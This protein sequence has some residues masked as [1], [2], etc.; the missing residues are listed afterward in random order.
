MMRKGKEG[1]IALP[2]WVAMILCAFIVGTGIGDAQIFNRGSGS[3]PAAPTDPGFPTPVSGKVRALKGQQITFELTSETKSPASIVEYLVRDFPLAGNIDSLQTKENA[4]SKAVMKYTPKLNTAAT[5]DVFTFSVRY[6][7]GRWSAP[8][9]FEIELIDAVPIMEGPVAVDF[10]QVMIG[11]EAVKEIYIRNSGNAIYDKTLK[12]QEPWHLV[13]PK[14]GRVTVPIGGSKM[15][16]VAFRPF[17]TESTTYQF[18]VNRNPGGV[19]QLR[20]D[21]FKPFSIKNPELK[22]VANDKNGTREGSITVISHAPKTIMLKVKTS[23]RLRLE[24]QSNELF[25]GPGTEKTVPVYLPSSDAA[26]FG[27]TIEVSADSGYLQNANITAETLPGRLSIEIPGSQGG[28]LINMGDVVAGQVAQSGIVLKNI[29]GEPINVDVEVQAPFKVLTSGTGTIKAQTAQPM[30]ISFN[31]TSDDSGLFDETLFLRTKN[32]QITVRLLAVAKAKPGSKKP[33]MRVGGFGTADGTGNSNN[34]SDADRPPGSTS[35]QPSGPPPSRAEINAIMA[36]IA[37]VQSMSGFITRP[38]KE[39]EI[40]ENLRPPTEF[41]GVSEKWNEITVK[42]QA[43]E[44]S[45]DHEFEMEVRN[46]LLNTETNQLESVWAPVTNV[47]YKRDNDEVFATVKGL[48]PLATY[49]FRVFTVNANGHSST[50]SIQFSKETPLPMDWTYIYLGTG[51]LIAGGLLFLLIRAVMKERR[52][53]SRMN[54]DSFIDRYG[55]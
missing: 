8:R 17:R 47:V 5:T 39:R 40:A 6:P 9:K 54:S 37:K 11:D 33:T 14:D 51:L 13:S 21:G 48:A 16:K 32:Q 19:T 55:Y 1:H 7:G 28:T 45:E 44:N 38:L 3:T 49:E 29:G 27:G 50:P 4:R 10:G 53:T 15:L 18:T 34:I 36:E 52:K 35:S 24:S 22:L 23:E 41:A 12:L 43:P 30:A 2:H 46:N 42:W 31:P 26:S 20:A 25:L